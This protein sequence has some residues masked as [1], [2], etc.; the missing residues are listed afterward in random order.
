MSA[1]TPQRERP[2]AACPR[3]RAARRAMR[4]G[5]A[6]CSHEGWGETAPQPPPREP[7]PAHV[8]AQATGHAPSLS[9]GFAGPVGCASG[10]I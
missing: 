10:V 4:V 3:A 5:V 1:H 2:L 8:E 6:E 7:L 9:L